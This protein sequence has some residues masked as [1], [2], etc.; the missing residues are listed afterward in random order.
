MAFGNSR[1]LKRFLL[2]SCLLCLHVTVPVTFFSG[3]VAGGG[4]IDKPILKAGRAY[5]K[6]KAKR[7]CWPRVRGVAMNVSLFSTGV[8]TSPFYGLERICLT[9]PGAWRASGRR[10]HRLPCNGTLNEGS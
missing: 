2:H 4:R 10:A 7:N 5:H 8:F 6:Y 3:I 1:V 9:Q